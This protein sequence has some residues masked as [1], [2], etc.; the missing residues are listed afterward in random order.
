MFQEPRGENLSSAIG[1]TQ[2][3]T[4]PAAVTAQSLYD[5]FSVPP[6]LQEHM[7]RVAAVAEIIAGRCAGVTVDFSSLMSACLLH[8]LG[9]IVKFEID[10]YPH[11]LGAEV[12]RRDYWEGVQRDMIERYGTDDHA[13]TA[14][15]LE[16]AGIPVVVRRLIDSKS[17]PHAIEIADGTDWTRK[18]FLYSDLRVAPLGIVSL[19]ERLDEA[20]ARLEKYRGRADLADAARRIES[21]LASVSS[22]LLTDADS[23]V[24]DSRIPELRKFP[25]PGG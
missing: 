1:Y 24:I 15:M 5:R 23:G 8:D 9:N 25:L 10:K 20:L 19:D 2:K 11:Y 22:P 21:Q 12:V 16:E 14:V 4:V 18:I 17:F 3:M 13:V 7:L 6:N